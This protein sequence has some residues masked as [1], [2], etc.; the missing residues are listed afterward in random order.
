M[1]SEFSHPKYPTRA[2]SLTSNVVTNLQSQI[3][4]LKTTIDTHWDQTLSA[5]TRT[6]YGL[7]TSAT[8]DD[9]FSKIKSLI[10]TAQ[11]TANS[12]GYVAFVTYTGT[13]VKPTSSSPQSITFPFAPKYI[14]YLGKGA[15][16]FILGQQSISSIS[17]SSSGGS[18]YDIVR[19]AGI[20]TSFM[21]GGGFGLQGSS[22]YTTYGKKSYDGKTF[23]WYSESNLNDDYHLCASGTIYSFIG[24]A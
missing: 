3:D 10:T 5:A 12:K 1:H 22:S 11:N 16:A 4:T 20:N 23:S 21:Y 7:G 9:I 2:G 15:S 14:I 19:L 13:G 18:F 17:S 8:P 6:L 24:L